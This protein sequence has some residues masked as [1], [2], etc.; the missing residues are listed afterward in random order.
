MENKKVLLWWFLY[1]LVGAL[2]GAGVGFIGGLIGG[3][4]SVTLGDPEGF[5][6][7]ILVPVI[8]GALIC[9]FF[10]FKWA[11]GKILD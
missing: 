10:V 1:N 2:A 6:A 8:I 9:N 4:I 11:V 3:I 7:L 5:E